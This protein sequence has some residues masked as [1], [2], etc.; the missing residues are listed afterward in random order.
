MIDLKMN[1]SY[2]KDFPQDADPV[3]IGK[4][5]VEQFLS[6]EPESYA[7]EGYDGGDVCGGGT[8]VMYAVV[9]LWLN[10]LQFARKINDKD[11]SDR[12]I[13]HFEPFFGEKKGKCSRDNHVDFSVFGSI[14]LEIFI[15]NGDQRAREMGLR[16]ADHQWE[17]PDP[18]NLGDTGNADYAT[19]LQYLQDGF[20]PQSRFWIEDMYMMTVLQTQAFRA[21]DD[22]R[23]LERTARQMD[24]YLERMQLPDGMFHHSSIAPFHWGRG[25]GWVA[26]GMPMLLKHLPESN[27]YFGRILKSYRLMMDSV[28]AYQH[29]SGLWGQLVDDADAWDESSCSGMFT[30][31]LVDGVNNG[32]LDANTFGP[33]AMKA[34]TALCRKMDKFGNIADVGA[35]TNC[36]N[37]RQFYLDRPRIN[38]APHGQAAMLWTVNSLL[39]A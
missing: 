14:P 20:S 19:Q 31:S 7:P 28:L 18:D 22:V 23:Y 26:G 1:N 6:V 33:A 38:G 25:N 34:W 21:T 3:E 16:Y 12:L 17:A 2:F 9:S 11:L 27:P 13:A 35:G 24:C 8:F 29:E 4:R 32:W 10:A 36:K 5:I 30:S 15:Q 37:D 39:D